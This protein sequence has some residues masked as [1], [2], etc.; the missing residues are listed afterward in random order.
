MRRL[1]CLLFLPMLLY[2]CV[3]QNQLWFGNRRQNQGN[4]NNVVRV[5]IDKRGSFYPDADFSIPKKE[6]IKGESKCLNISTKEY[7]GNLKSYFLAKT[8]RIDSLSK[9]YNVN[10]NIPSKEQFKAV[11]VKIL[12]NLSNTIESLKQANNTN[13]LVILIHGYNADYPTPNYYEL[14]NYIEH[15]KPDK[16]RVFL[17]VYWDGLTDKGK[18]FSAMKIWSTAQ[19]N[20]SY[21]ANAVRKIINCI[22]VTT[23]VRLITH[24]LGASVGTGAL[25]NTTSKWTNVEE[26][27]YYEDMM[28]T[29]A[30]TQ[31][32]IRLGMIAPAIPGTTT[33]KDFNHRKDTRTNQNDTILPV[34]N[35]I[36]RVIIGYKETD[37]ALSKKFLKKKRYLSKKVG[38][39]SLGANVE[40]DGQSEID[41]TKDTM[42][43]IG[44]NSENLPVYEVDF[45]DNTYPDEHG[46]H[47]YMQNKYALDQ[48]LDLLFD[49]KINP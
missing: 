26:K 34:N 11:Q 12:E 27:G 8:T 9:H 45:K 1:V 31:K 47:F 7:N 32:D 46:L 48:F 43:S 28:K 17:E 38:A 13:E 18:G 6:F 20:S 30:P 3:A 2:G 35:N 10:T 36:K 42:I 44:Y 4:Q 16:R 39:T 49:E 25:F 41:R 40:T 23:K 24:S 15:F 19:M 21:V 5:Y 14:E 37:E 29:L 22:D 33:F